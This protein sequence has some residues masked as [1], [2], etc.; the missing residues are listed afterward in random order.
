MPA[1]GDQGANLIAKKN[2][3]TIAIQANGYACR[4]RVQESAAALRFYN[5]DE[6][7]VLGI[8]PLLKRLGHWHRLTIMRLL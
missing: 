2:G 8:A 4:K 6:G 3:R 1:T 7:W 5:A